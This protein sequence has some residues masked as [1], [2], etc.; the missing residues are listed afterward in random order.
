MR[1]LII[2]LNFHPELTGIGKY[3]GE[4]AAYLSNA[5]HRVRVITAPP[6]YPY[7][8]V[9]PG[10]RW[11][12]YQRESWSGVEVYRCPL[13]VPRKPSGLKRIFHLLSFALSSLPVLLSQFFWPPQIVLCV[14]PSLFSAPA[15]L[16]AARLCGAKAWLHVQ[17]FELEAAASLGM[18]GGENRLT[19]LAARLESRLMRAFDRVSTISARMQARLVVKGLPP[20][21]TRLFPNWVDINEIYPL[22]DG[23][24]A[25]RKELVLPTDK[26][27][28]LYAGNMGVK[29]GLEILV[30]AAWGLRKNSAIHFVLCGEGSARAYLER[31]ARELRNVQFLP[32]QPPEKL[33]TLL[34]AADIHVLPQRAD[35]A[36]LVMPSKLLGML[37]SGKVIV[38]LAG[39]D[40]EIGNV[41]SQIGV[42]V[43]PGDQP[44]LCEAILELGIASQERTRLGMKGRA[45]VCKHWSTERVL[46]TFELQLRELIG[47]QSK[48]LSKSL[49]VKRRNSN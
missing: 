46:G 45:F 18:L 5:G 14:A 17:D 39:P 48:D 29:Q 25:A 16:L 49:L 28:V 15:A 30:E 13:W 6:Y 11:W 24:G 22:P 10:Y 32:L 34:N 9:Q 37:A 31:A 44:A 35:A 33:N 40:T 27:V 19:R 12:K 7:W 1:I 26:V 3:T 2:G 36:D 43:P 38:A 47:G 4:M 8:K 41:V 23:G 20:E 42:L 21:R